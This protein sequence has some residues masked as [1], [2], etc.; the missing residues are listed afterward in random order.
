MKLF[1]SL[2]AFIWH[3]NTANN[4]NTYLI[5]GPTPVLIDPGHAAHFNHVQ[6]GLGELNLSPEDMGMV[7]ITH[8]HPD[9]IEAVPLFKEKSTLIAIHEAE[10]LLVK[11]MAPYLKS[12]L[13]LNLDAFS[14]D[15]FLKEGSFSYNNMKFEVFHTPGH[16]P[17]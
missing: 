10:W 17:G 13:G 14:P 11:S 15:I 8:A 4:C 2:H 16:S 5:D 7:I 1:D 9:H 6:K 12:V 3:S